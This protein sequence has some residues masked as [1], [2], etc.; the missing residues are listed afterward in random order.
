MEIADCSYVNKCIEIAL[1]MNMHC[2]LQS[3]T[4]R[5]SPVL[6]LLPLHLSYLLATLVLLTG[7]SAKNRARRVD[8]TQVEHIA[9]TV[10]MF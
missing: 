8:V 5:L 1:T 3:F 2:L 10:D 6:V 9:T 4:S 7:V